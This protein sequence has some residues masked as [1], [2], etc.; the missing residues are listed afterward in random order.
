MTGTPFTATARSSILTWV[1]HFKISAK[2]LFVLN[3]NFPRSFEFVLVINM[4]LAK[5]SAIFKIIILLN[6]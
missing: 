5:T 3:F 1:V 2:L 6:D 4:G